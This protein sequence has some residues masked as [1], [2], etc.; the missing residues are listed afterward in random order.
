V[1]GHNGGNDWGYCRPSQEDAKVS[2]RVIMDSA[3]VDGRSNRDGFEIK[4][5]GDKG[6]TDYVFLSDNG[7]PKGEKTEKT[8]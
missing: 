4:L 3:M 8:I 2:Y 7:F 1:D 5:T 6:K